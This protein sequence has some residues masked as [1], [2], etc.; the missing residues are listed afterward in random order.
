M[1]LSRILILIMLVAP[2][3][4]ADKADKADKKN[5]SRPSVATQPLTLPEGAEQIEPFTWRY[6][7]EDGKTWIY[8][9]IPFGLVRFEEKE[10][11]AAGEAPAVS[12][13]A[14]EDGDNIRFERQ[15]PFGPFRWVRKKTHELSDEEREAWERVRDKKNA[16]N[17]NADPE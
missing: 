9:R 16:G 15:G 4:G 8:R 6:T 13:K 2:A 3:V 11:A 5:A 12:I 7:D 1:I 17:K 10:K 14:V